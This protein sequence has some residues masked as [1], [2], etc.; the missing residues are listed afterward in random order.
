MAI[1]S[2]LWMLTQG[3]RL[4]WIMGVDRHWVFSSVIG[5]LFVWLTLVASWRFRFISS[6]HIEW[7]NLSYDTVRALLT[8]IE[9]NLWAWWTTYTQRRWHLLLP[10]SNL[11]LL[12]HLL[13]LLWLEKVPISEVSL[14]LSTL[15]AHNKSWSFN[16]LR[17]QSLLMIKSTATSAMT[18]PYSRIEWSRRIS[19]LAAALSSDASDLLFMI[20]VKVTIL[21]HNWLPPILQLVLLI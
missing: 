15:S 13:L 7:F 4:G 2:I 16:S 8:S 19:L 1:V 6:D 17:V 20:K 3:W 18:R 12:L 5:P 11:V 9:F 14:R 10:S 21:D